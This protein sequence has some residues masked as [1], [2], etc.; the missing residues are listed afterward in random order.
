LERL[1]EKKPFETCFK[2]EFLSK[3]MQ[4]R[5]PNVRYFG[6]VLRRLFD[7]REPFDTALLE[8]VLRESRGNRGVPVS[9]GEELGGKIDFCVALLRYLNMVQRV[10]SFHM[11]FV[12]RVLL[13]VAFSIGL[14]NIN[15][16]SVKFYSEL[17][18]YI[19]KNYLPVLNRKENRVL[20]AVHRTLSNE[21][22]ISSFEFANVP[23]GGRVVL[24][25]NKEFNAILVR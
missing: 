11:V 6:D 21:E 23:D 2:V 1:S 8:E 15:K 7:L 5:E 24:L 20:D 16:P 17:L 13:Q 14:E 9:P 19:D 10:D 12:P 4:S 18:D 25:A 22:F 3:I